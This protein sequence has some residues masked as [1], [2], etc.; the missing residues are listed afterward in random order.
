ME[1]I[2][3]S[4]FS[5][6][7]G[8][9][10][11]TWLV[12]NWITERLK[13]SI[14]HEYAQK[15][16]I[17]KAELNSKLQSIIHDKQLY[18]L[19][20][21]LFFDHQRKAFAEL[22]SQLAKTIDIWFN[23]TFDPEES[24]MEP[25]P[26]K[27]Y[28]IFKN[29]FYEHQL[30][31]DSECQISIKLALQAME[32]SFPYKDTKYGPEEKKECYE[33]YERLGY[34]Q[35]RMIEIFQEKIGI[36]SALTAKRDLAFLTLIRLLNENRHNISEFKVEGVIVLSAV[37]RYSDAV[38]I[39]KQYEESFLI[40]SKELRDYLSNQILFEVDLQKVDNAI[41]ILNKNKIQPPN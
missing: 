34:I 8:G 3:S 2:I 15:L 35:E 17:H 24:F 4:I 26:Y 21:S 9:V 41:N 27:E 28:Q 11:L 30:F 38:E 33:V 31:F 18:N 32:D 36:S 5:G 37:E 12:R 13:E 25:V 10:F 14:K 22:S 6:A 19:R 40:K 16:E 39:A 29:L 7:I 20:T 23:E 1:T